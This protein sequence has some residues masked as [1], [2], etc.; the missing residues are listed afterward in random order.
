[1][2]SNPNKSNRKDHGRSKDSKGRFTGKKS[3]GK[4]K[5]K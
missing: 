2:S 3:A 1:V 4:K 5:S